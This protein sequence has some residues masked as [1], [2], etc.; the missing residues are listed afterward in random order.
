MNAIILLPT[1]KERENIRQYIPRLFGLLPENARIMVVDDN[2]PDGT[3]EE[4]RA[5]Q[6]NYPRLLLY[7]RPK[8]EGLG[9]AYADAFRK[10]MREYPEVE[11]IV[12]MDADM[13]HDEKQLPAMLA[14]MEDCDLVT[15]SR[16]VRGGR[17]VGWELWR[18]LLSSLG[19][20]YVRLVTRLP[21]NDATAGFNCIRV[22]VLKKI[23]F[24]AIDPSGYAFLI[25]LKYMLW[26]D[27][28]RIAERP[29]TFR[30][31]LTGES[32]ISMH[33]IEEGILMPWK[34]VRRLPKKPPAPCPICHAPNG[35]WWFKKN[36]CDLYRCPSCRLVFICPLPEETANIYSQDYFCGAHGGF[37][38]VN[39]DADKEADRKTF[40][41]YLDRIE[42]ARPQRDR[43]LDVGAATGAFLLSAK[44]RGWDAAGL[45]IS[46]FA[47]GIG[48]GKGLNIQTGTIETAN[49]EDASFD[50]ITLWDAFE[51][52]PSPESALKRIRGLIAPGGLLVMNLPDTGSLYARLM[53][54]HWPL[55][56]PPEHVHLFRE[57][58]LRP[59]LERH[60]FEWIL[61]TK[62]GK[63]YPPAYIFQILSTVHGSKIWKK[64]S[65]YVRT[66][67]LNR[68]AIPIHL[69]DN[70][71]IIAKR[72]N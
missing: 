23:N 7:E 72:K 52:L 56:I 4:T 51:H 22:S 70:M 64:I 20:R 27:G 38:Y 37:G 6:K 29:I 26:R 45:E 53:G 43:L 2:S 28:A 16:Y 19:N 36:D 41:R 39:Y 5:L 42:E 58:N 32:K 66:T 62:I 1:Y 9:R 24:S 8:K 67:P 61:K 13:S 17:T 15:G 33:I 60:G 48:R 14:A 11:I 54:R 46:D 12:T 3:A 47:A 63:S 18:K 59:L 40:A 65:D 68:V 69:R 10:V 49:F 44:R 71:F 35:A 57:E 30:N 50:V 55:I 34:L 21:I 31:R 25:A